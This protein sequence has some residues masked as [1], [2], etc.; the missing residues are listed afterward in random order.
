MVKEQFRKKNTTRKIDGVTFGIMGAEDMRKQ[1]HIQVVSKNLY[2]PTS[3]TPVPFG[4]LDHRLGTSEKDNK[5]ETCGQ[6]LADCVGHFGFVDLALPCFHVGYFRSV[7]TILQNICKAC[8]RVLLPPEEHKRMLEMA[9]RTKHSSLA[10][11]NM[12]KKL[13]ERCRKIHTC[14]YC[15]DFN[16]VVKRC[17]LLKIVHD[18]Y[19]STRRVLEPHI[20]E[21]RSSFKPALEHNNQLQPLLDKTQEM[22]SPLRILEIFRQM[23]DEDIHLLSMDP[24]ATRP[25]DLI[26]RR[27]AVPPLCIRPSVQTGAGGSNEDD[28]SMKLTE[29]I[30]LNDFIQKNC[31][32]GAKAALIMEEWDFLQ[33]QVALYINSELSGIPLNFQPKKTNARICPAPEG[34]A[35]SLPWQ[36]V[37]QTCGFLRPNCHLTRSQHENRPGVRADPRSQGPDVSRACHQG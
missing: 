31:E 3:R 13:H 17:G 11:R 6:P 5:C 29:I 19:K 32:Q 7:I 35:R 28:L 18:K 33:L 37:W 36:S 26:L 12:Q 2:T 24:A 1:A 8:A 14:P 34:Q 22:L 4:V 30:F 21:F 25:E 9:K 23:S 20:A 16:G 10:R 27:L 15:G